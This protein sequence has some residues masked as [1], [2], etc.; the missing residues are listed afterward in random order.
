MQTNPAESTSIK[1]MRLF[2]F[3]PLRLSTLVFG[4]DL[5]NNNNSLQHRG[6]H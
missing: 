1:I 6:E 5:E 4:F 3:I 2:F